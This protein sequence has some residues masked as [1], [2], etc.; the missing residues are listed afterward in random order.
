MSPN[1]F[2]NNSLH[3]SW[4]RIAPA[5]LVPT[6]TLAPERGSPPQQTHPRDVEERHERSAA[7]PFPP[8]P[9]V[10]QVPVHPPSRSALIRM[11]TPVIP[12]SRP[13]DAT[14]I[15]Q[16][17]VS[18]DATPIEPEP[19]TVPREMTP[20]PPTTVTVPAPFIA[21]TSQIHVKSR[22]QDRAPAQTLPPTVTEPPFQP[23]KPAAPTPAAVV[24]ECDARPPSLSGG[25]RAS[26]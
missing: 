5:T 15:A 3:P 18:V 24:P 9:T 23:T 16:P 10:I 13:P 19:P 11:M 25:D 14:T 8:H 12:R 1:R 7:T 4:Y 20:H 22:T 21:L 2:P 17:P 26:R 6:S